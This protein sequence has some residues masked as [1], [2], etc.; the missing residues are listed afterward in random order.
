MHFPLTAEQSRIWAAGVISGTPN[1]YN[2]PLA[3]R[4]EGM[5]D[6]AAL[7][8]AFHG[9]VAAHEV[10]RLRFV[11]SPDGPIQRLG[12]H[13]LPTIRRLAP[14]NQEPESDALIRWQAEEAGRPFDLA[15]ESPI[16]AA[17]ATL[18]L[19]EH[20]LFITLHH[21][22]SDGYSV[23]LLVKDLERRYAGECEARLSG[24]TVAPPV[25]PVG[26]A[27][28][29]H[30][31][32][33]MA[34][35]GGT[36]ASVPPELVPE[37]RATG[38][39]D[40]RFGSDLPNAALVSPGDWVPIE[41]PEA[42]SRRLAEQARAGGSTVFSWL[43]A[44]IVALMHRHTGASDITVGCPMSTRFDGALSDVMGCFVSTVP[45]H[46]TLSPETSIDGLARDIRAAII[47]QREG[48]AAAASS[49]RAPTP[50]AW[51]SGTGRL[52]PQILVNLN[53]N[54]EAALTLAGLGVVPLPRGVRQVPFDLSWTV[55][56]TA[57]AVR[58]RIEFSA[59]LFDRATML[60]MAEQ[61]QTLL[62][63]AVSDPEGAV[64]GLKVLSE[65]EREHVL[66]VGKGPGELAQ[67]ERGVHELFEAQA[68]S[69]P[70]AVAV[71]CGG[72]TLS[73]RELDEWSSRVAWR[74]HQAYGVRAE[75]RV[76]I[77]MERSLEMVVALLGVLKAGAAYVP[78]DPEHPGPRLSAQ[79]RDA[80]VRVVLTQQHLRERLPVHEGVTL[81]LD[82][83]EP[84]WTQGPVNRVGEQ[85]SPQQ[86][87]YCIYTSGSTGQPKAVMVSHRG[88]VRL[89]CEPGYVTLGPEDRLLQ[90]SP[91]AFDAST[92]EIWGALLNG[93]CLV[94]PPPGVPTLS[95]LGRLVLDHAITTLWL[96]AALFEQ[97]CESEIDALAP[98]R[99]MLSGG[100]V[101]SASAVSKVLRRWP[102]CRMING[103]G[104]TETTTFAT[105]HR[106]PTTFAGGRAPIGRPIRGTQAYVLDDRLEP[107]P[108]GV[109]GAL[110]IAGA[111]VARGYLNQPAL[112]AERFLPDP[113]GAPGSRMYR[114]GDLARMRGDGEIEFLGR[115]D[116]QVKIRGFRVELD[117]IEHEIMAT[118]LVREAV[119]LDRPGEAGGRTLVACVVPAVVALGTTGRISAGMSA[120]VPA[121]MVPSDWLVMDALPLTPNGKVD[122]RRL[123]ADIE[124][125]A[126]RSSDHQ[127]QASRMTEPGGTT[128]SVVLG[129][130][131][132][133]LPQRVLDK[134]DDLFTQGLHS[135]LLIQLIARCRERF[136][137]DLRTREVHR[138]GTVARIAAAIDHQRVST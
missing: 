100:D 126:V 116:R 136:G 115:E 19:L 51:A 45:L 94:V 54:Y 113:F 80:G 110:H 85:G 32:A 68:A 84:G 86:L 91:L 99:Q 28:R 79:L 53:P 12:G 82:D 133:L 46:C 25:A 65:L 58:G 18:G 90:V 123:A 7:E 138:C 137:V 112:T 15:N 20:V 75:S 49:A 64:G 11:E 17:L 31:Q 104:P 59:D 47:A 76:A 88:I 71:V 114:T 69:T 39:G 37:P 48:L 122:R 27:Y 38:W 52:L 92:F 101:L 4:V 111:G 130:V 74:L 134:D 66:A 50:L 129:L 118:G 36:C 103:Y 14:I 63:S 102:R 40:I 78:M 95:E 56:S 106:F 73:Y 33:L 93:A 35:P 96:T 5:L 29:R 23:G 42:I 89:V 13:A 132:G 119:A 131:S 121:H 16:R 127:A 8:R 77:A 6:V 30:L 70:E 44:A 24:A 10:L 67:D 98:V 124:R 107:V 34:A 135:L 57:P 60:R 105:T 125:A 109:T 1:L 41:V 83:G 97:F 55:M 62:A 61:F 87:A 128:L 81:A 43:T 3:W 120:R 22:V 117:E 26:D 9:M 2:L 108:F 21:L 72:R